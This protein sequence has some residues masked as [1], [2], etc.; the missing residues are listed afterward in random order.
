MRDERKEWVVKDI[1]R[2]RQKA[3]K[4]PHLITFNGKPDVD[5]KSWTDPDNSSQIELIIN[6]RHVGGAQ[7]ITKMK[8]K[9]NL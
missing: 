9:L 8:D 7:V 3:F 5:I 6:V 1:R 4:R 2:W